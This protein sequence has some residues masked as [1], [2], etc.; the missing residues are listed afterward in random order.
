NWYF[1]RL[2]A[3]ISIALIRK[4]FFMTKSRLYSK[5]ALGTGALLLFLLLAFLVSH[6]TTL[7][8]TIDQ[9]AI[10]LL[11]PLVTPTLTAVIAFISNLASPAMMTV[12]SLIIA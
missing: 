5:F 4:E 10:N 12:Y 9:G 6:H 7:I 11:H 3:I 8:T 2:L 1:Q